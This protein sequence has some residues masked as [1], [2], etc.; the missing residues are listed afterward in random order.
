[1]AAFQVITE[2]IACCEFLRRQVSQRTVWAHPVVI[3]PPTFDGLSCVVQVQE[4]VLVQTFLAELSM[5]ALDVPVFHRPAWRDEVQRD[6]V[7]I[8]P[9]VERL[10]SELRAI[11]DDDPHRSARCCRSFSSTRTTRRDGNEVSTS[12]ASISRVYASSMESVRTL[13]PDANASCKK[14][15]VQVSLAR[16]GAASSTRA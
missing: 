7:F 10:G 13:R 2:G 8:G 11:V 15:I 16:I 4:P 12:M 14:S 1:M 3:D 6:F 5:E 9:L